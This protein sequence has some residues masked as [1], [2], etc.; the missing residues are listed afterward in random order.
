[1]TKK[2]LLELKLKLEAEKTSLEKELSG[3]AVKDPKLNGD[4][5]TKMPSFDSGHEE[6]EQDEMEEYISRLP[7]EHSLELQ[8]KDV[9]LALEKIKNKGY[10]KCEKCEKNISSKR[11]K[12][13]P[14]A[15]TCSKCK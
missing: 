5:D 1:M 8:L 2:L 9:N 14:A 15:R 10:G 6:E 11:L 13:Y 3:F 12:I 7:V 4:W